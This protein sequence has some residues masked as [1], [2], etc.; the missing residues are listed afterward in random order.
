L[1]GRWRVT[2]LALIFAAAAVAGV[3]RDGRAAPA[4]TT[5]VPAGNDHKGYVGTYQYT[6]CRSKLVDTTYHPG[7]VIRIKWLRVPD[8]SPPNETMVIS[9]EIVGPFSTSDVLHQQLSAAGLLRASSRSIQ[10]VNT[11]P[12]SP[13][14]VIHIPR[15]AGPGYYD[16]ETQ[17]VYKGGSGGYGI[18]VIRIADR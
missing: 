9:A 17:T 5:T 16:L 14:S 7:G 11:D 4:T 6:C 3:V 10:L 15:D 8:S 1:S 13:R 12:L 18:T 2:A